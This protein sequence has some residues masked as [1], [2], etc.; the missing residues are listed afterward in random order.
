MKNLLF[1]LFLSVSFWL[2][3]QDFSDEWTGYFAYAQTK[4]ITEGNG[5]VYVA[6]DNAV[7]AYSTL[8]GSLTTKSTINGLSGQPISSIYYS[9]AFETLLVGY[10]NGVIDVVIEGNN[11][12][13]TVVDIFNKPSIPPTEKR[14][15]HFYEFNGFVYISTGFGISLFD[16]GRLEFDDSYFIGDNGASL[17]IFETIVY[18][19]FIYAATSSGL[20][21]ALVGNTNIIDFNNWTTTNN[22]T[23]RGLAVLNETL[24]G[25]A[26]RNVLKSTNGVNFSFAFMYGNITPRDIRSTAT[27][28]IVTLPE[29]ILIYDE[30]ENL[31]RT[32]GAVGDFVNDYSTALVLNNSAFISTR[33]SGMIEVPLTNGAPRQYLP[34][35]PLEND[36]FNIEAAVNEV[37]AVYGS[38]NVFYNPF[39]LTEKGLSHFVIDS[40]WTNISFED[41]LFTTDM[42][43]VAINPQNPSQVFVPSFSAG[44][45]EINDEVPT[46]LFD[47][48]NSPLER[49]FD[50]NGSDGGVRINSG[51]FDSN[52]NLWISNSFA[53]NGLFRVTPGGQFQ[54]IS[55]TEAFPNGDIPSGL[56][57]I[58]FGSDGNLFLGTNSA[59]LIGYNPNSG[60]LA[61]ISGDEG[62]AN[63]PSDDIRALAVDQGGTLWIGTR[64]GLR[65]LFSPSSIFEEGETTTNPIIILQ[66]DIPQELLNDQVITE[67]VVDGSNNKWISTIGSGV[68]FVSPNGQETLA[69]FTRNNSPLPSNNVNS[70]SIDPQSGTIYFATDQGMVS[71]DGTSQPPA[72]SLENVGV[73]PNPV[74]PTFSGEV[75]IDGLT[76]RSNVK[77]TDLVG[78]LVYEENATAGN[79]TWDTT[80]FGRHK[81]ASGVYLI[82]VT[83]PDALETNIVKLLIIR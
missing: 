55:I 8:D 79:L 1:L 4:D 28:L 67:I 68:F 26:G 19:E 29:R 32:I 6:A 58:V 33:G 72:E 60:A 42:V 21:R 10:E 25:I 76:A 37:W 75:T 63:L 50:I 13:L 77:I 43:N 14:I 36:I 56:D 48:T 20:R 7:F 49:V 53:D 2:Q 46:M 65:L 78:N 11:N 47:D 40:G 17:N 69:N 51:T 41:A 15:N 31:T 73:Y 12:V 57:D 16:L 34:D 83:G 44:L 30:D 80:A 9:A 39:P 27:Q 23:F 61:R 3:G 66:D 59:G 5:V 52:N 81:V 22:N 62:A 74:R 70:M 45:L 38:Y 64:R 24:Y 18:G 35:G 82:L 71:F 54:G